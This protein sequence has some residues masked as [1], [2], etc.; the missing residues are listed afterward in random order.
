M[1]LQNAV[2]VAVVGLIG[3]VS[4]A[5]VVATVRLMWR[6]RAID[7]AD[8]PLVEAVSARLAFAERGYQAW[9]PAIQSSPT[10]TNRPLANRIARGHCGLGDHP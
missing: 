2:M 9:L 5:L 6:L 10:P 1:L 4:A 7:R 3:L 8:Q